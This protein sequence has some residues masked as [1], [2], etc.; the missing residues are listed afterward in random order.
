ELSSLNFYNQDLLVGELY[1]ESMDSDM[2][3]LSACDTGNGQMFNGEGIQSVSKAFTYAGVPS[4]VMSLWKVDDK[5]TAILMG[6][7]YKYLN[8]GKPK[9]VALKW[10]KRDYVNSTMDSELKHPYYWSGF[11]I[12]GNVEPFKVQ[13]NHRKWWLSLLI[14]PLAILFFYRKSKFGK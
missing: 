7:F 14:V 3:V 1:N 12:S 13:E 6:S 5:A 10:A 2:V 8:A 11:V 4:T 9:D